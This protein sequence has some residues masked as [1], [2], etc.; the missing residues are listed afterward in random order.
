MLLYIPKSYRRFP[1]WDGALP[2]VPEGIEIRRVEEDLGPATKLL[3]ALREFE[4]QEI[5]LLFCDDDMIA[6]KG[7]AKRFLEER[8]KHPKACLCT[9]AW[10][11]PEEGGRGEMLIP[12]AERNPV[13]WDMGYH[14]RYGVRW[15][16]LKLGLE[17][18][19]LGRH[20]FRKG[21]YMDV[22]EGFGGV[23]V[24]PG[25]FD[26]RVFEAPS[27]A[28]AVDDVWLSGMALAT[29]CP[30]WAMAHAPQPSGGPG[31]GRAALLDA[32]IEGAGRS[33]AEM[34][35]IAYLRKTYGI[36]R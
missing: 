6:P 32:V 31:S 33:E 14:L 18:G 34:A 28:F 4:G 35:S 5:D 16:A 23:M 29:G 24:R 21:G 2:D 26:A 30:T 11:V 20:Q 8:E 12:R 17:R 9:S 10:D 7:W 1:E 3:P 36:W 13:T 19:F 27:E 25:F 22:F 15:A